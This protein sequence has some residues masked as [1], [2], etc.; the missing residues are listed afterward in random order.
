MKTVEE[1]YREIAESKELQEELKAASDEMM[2]A[3]L[4]KH[5]CDASVKDFAAFVRSQDEG[6]IEDN[7]AE[8][9]AGGLYYQPE[10]PIS[11]PPVI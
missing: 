4:K 3:V 8:E 2:K 1:F 6:E 9:I 10:S 11:V 7:D 5:G